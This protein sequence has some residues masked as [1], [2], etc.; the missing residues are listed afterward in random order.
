MEAMSSFSLRFG[1]YLDICFPGPLA[2][3]PV[4]GKHRVESPQPTALLCLRLCPGQ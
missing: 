3:E 1:L 2:M 4:C